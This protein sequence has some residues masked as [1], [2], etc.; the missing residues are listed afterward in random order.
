VDQA[1]T[2]FPST[3]PKHLARRSKERSASAGTAATQAAALVG[4][5][6]RIRVDAAACWRCSISGSPGGGGRPLSA[7]EE[8][9][10]PCPVDGPSSAWTPI[11]PVEPREIARRRGNTTRILGTHQ[12]IAANQHVVARDEG[13]QTPRPTAGRGDRQPCRGTRTEVPASLTPESRLDYRLEQIAGSG[14]GKQRRRIQAAAR[15][16][17]SSRSG[18]P[19]RPRKYR[20]EIAASAPAEQPLH[21]SLFGE[22]DG[23]DARDGRTAGRR[24]Y[25]P[26]VAR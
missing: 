14:P 16:S 23:G 12:W 21:G 10:V 15:C 4:I 7:T 13:E 11:D 22:I 8:K 5:G 3:P 6:A 17:A 26:V 19:G 18:K 24:M 20:E 2:E 25:A 9:V 1:R